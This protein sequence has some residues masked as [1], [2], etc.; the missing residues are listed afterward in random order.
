MLMSVKVTN[1]IFVVVYLQLMPTILAENLL[2]YTS[3]LGFAIRGNHPVIV[4]P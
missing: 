1:A 3:A 2:P 4:N